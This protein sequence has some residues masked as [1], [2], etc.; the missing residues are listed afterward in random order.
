M[1][2]PLSVSI[3]HYVSD[4]R[5][6]RSEGKKVE[7]RNTECGK[8]RFSAEKVFPVVEGICQGQNDCYSGF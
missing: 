3:S 2:E 7:T 6:S 1:E 5:F 4:F 8:D